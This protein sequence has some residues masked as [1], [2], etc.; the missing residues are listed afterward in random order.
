MTTVYRA[1]HFPDHFDPLDA[2][3]SVARAG[4]RFN[5]Q[6]TPILYAAEVQSLAILEVAA[7]PAWAAIKELAIFPI[8][9]PGEI[10]TLDELGIVLPTNWNNRPSAHSARRI[11]AES[12]HFS[13]EDPTASP[14]NP[15]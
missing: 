6:D 14:R 5:D 2:T 11:G 8:T 3:P 15:V 7:R 4:W 12:G 10:V 13:G 9:V 1:S